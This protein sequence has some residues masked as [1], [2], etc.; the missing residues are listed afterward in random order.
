MSTNSGARSRTGPIAKILLVRLDGIG[1]ALACTPLILALREAGHTLGAALSDRNATLFAPGVFAAQHVLDRIPWPRHGSTPESTARARA[2]IAAMQYDVALVASEEPEA[3]RL[4]AGIRERVGFVT[5]WAKPFKT[6]WARTQ[7]TRAI[8]RPA[9]LRAQAH[10]VEILYELGRG[11]LGVQAPSREPLVPSRDP[12][13]PSR[14]PVALRTIVQGDGP[15]PERHG[16]VLQLGTK[17]AALG[18]APERLR[19]LSRSLI[20]RGARA[21][22]SPGEVEAIRAITRDVPI[23]V[24]PTLADWKD[25]VDRAA[26]LVSPDTGAVHLAG[27]LGVPVVAVFGVARADAQ[28][29]RWRPWAA[30]GASFTSDALRDETGVAAIVAAAEAAAHG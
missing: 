23:D 30:P 28:I 26:V 10:E 18:V 7:L 15:V 2:S 25:A 1:D 6:L 17:W 22:A 21:I 16:I 29:A 8:F 5:G 9:S 4:A 13:V 11:Y 27:M 24:L 3:Y 12:L 20:A 14:D 19:A